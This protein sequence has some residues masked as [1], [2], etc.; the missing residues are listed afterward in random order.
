MTHVGR[1]YVFSFAFS[2]REHDEAKKKKKKKLEN[3]ALC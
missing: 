1:E 2:G 3:L